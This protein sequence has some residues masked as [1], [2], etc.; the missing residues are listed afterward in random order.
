MWLV[1]DEKQTLSRLEQSGCRGKEASRAIATATRP[2]RGR[3]RQQALEV[4]AMYF[5]CCFP[6]EAEKK[7]ERK[8]YWIDRAADVRAGTDGGTNLRSLVTPMA[9]TEWRSGDRWRHRG[10]FDRCVATE[11]TALRFYPA[12][13][14]RFWHSSLLI[15]DHDGSL[16]LSAE[17]PT[18]NFVCRCRDSLCCL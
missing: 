2:G 12:P 1:G 5:F 13:P 8:G 6:T 17:N 16:R 18:R 7:R 9:S 15:A 4:P 11:V 14:L 10:F 3:L